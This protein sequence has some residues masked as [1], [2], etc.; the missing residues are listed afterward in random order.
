MQENLKNLRFCPLFAHVEDADLP[1]LLACLNGTTA[2]FAKKETILAEGD[3]VQHICVL[4]SGA[5]QI[6]QSD[7]FG[8]RSIVASIEPPQL[9]SETFAC[10]GVETM[11]VSVVA[12]EDSQVLFIDCQRITHACT[13][14]C[15]FH[16]QIIDNLLRIV[17]TKNLL[18]HQKI[19]ITAKRSTREKL[20]T[21][22]LLQSKN[23]QSPE[24]DIPYDRQALA[25]YLEV[26]RSGLSAEISKLRAEGVL[27]CRKNHFTLLKDHN[28]P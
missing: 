20:M 4:L 9:F 10:A 24:F 22:L 18:F 19:Q 2:R 17:A 14:A 3:P 28:T 21:Y 27:T 5:A 7:Y 25:D 12:T 26:E 16:R 15:G 6:E 11:P 23:R 1:A 13:N 8:N